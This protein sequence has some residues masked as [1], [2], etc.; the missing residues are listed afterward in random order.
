MTTA[1]DLM[2]AYISIDIQDTVAQLIGKFKKGS[3]YSA[4]VFDGKK[5]L[6]MVEKHSLAN[7]KGDSQTMKVNNLIKHR[8]KA[9]T[10]FY[11]PTL[12]SDA[13][14]PEICKKMIT[15]DTHALPV[16][17]GKEVLGIV[18]AEDVALAIAKE[19]KGITCDKLASK[20]P[21]TCTPDDSIA[22]AVSA[23]NREG[24]DHLPIADEKNQLLGM[25]SMSDI[26]NSEELWNSE[27]QHLS[28]AA[29]HQQGKHTGYQHGEKTSL[30]SLPVK[31]FMTKKST[32]CTNPEETIPNI[33][34][35]M[36]QE[37]VC[38]IILV[39]NNQPVGILTLKDILKD[40]AKPRR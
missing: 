31:N 33:V 4:V 40:Y 22:K 14:L 8:S 13:E 30:S 36:Q 11:V 10:P 20:K 25:V 24:I 29:S 38:S 2:H 35:K 5:Y 15:G 6:G 19:Y 37:K 16:L 12:A 18:T 17:D 26:L 39:K 23:L 7:N 27:R 9:Q 32:C 34:K 21:L 28:K 1:Q 3:T